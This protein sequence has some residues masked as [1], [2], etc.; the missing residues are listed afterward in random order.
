MYMHHHIVTALCLCSSISQPVQPQ[1]YVKR[2]HEYISEDIYRCCNPDVNAPFR[3]LQDALDRLLPYHVGDPLF[4]SLIPFLNK[5]STGTRA[6]RL[7]TSL[8]S[9]CAGVSRR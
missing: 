5:V 4:L 1:P 7:E 2:Q 9:D 3:N 8:S 6:E